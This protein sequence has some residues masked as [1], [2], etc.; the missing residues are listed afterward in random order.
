MKNKGDTSEISYSASQRQPPKTKPNP[1]QESAEGIWAKH[2]FLDDHKNKV[3]GKITKMDAPSIENAPV[4]LQRNRI[5]DDFGND[6]TSMKLSNFIVAGK[7]TY[8]GAVSENMGED[9]AH[10][11]ESE[12][13][14]KTTSQSSR[15]ETAQRKRPSSA[16]INSR[17]ETTALPSSKRDKIEKLPIAPSSEPSEK[18]R[19]IHMEPP[20]FSNNVIAHKTCTVIE[21]K[22]PVA[23]SLENQLENMSSISSCKLENQSMQ[24]KVV[25]PHVPPKGPKKAEVIFIDSGKH[26]RA[27]SA[28]KASPSIQ[29][30]KRVEKIKANFSEVNDEMGQISKNRRNSRSSIQS[31]GNSKRDGS[32][33]PNKQRPSSSGKNSNLSPV[34]QPSKPN[35][36]QVQSKIKDLI[37]KDKKTYTSS[38]P[39]FSKKNEPEVLD[40]EYLTEEGANDNDCT[41]RSRQDN[42]KTIEVKPVKGHSNRGS[43]ELSGGHTLEISRDES[44]ASV[45]SS[46]LLNKE[47]APAQSKWR[48][49]NK[50]RSQTDDDA[51]DGVMRIASNL[52]SSNILKRFN[53][54]S[55]EKNHY[56]KNDSLIDHDSGQEEDDQMTG[57]NSNK[58]DQKYFNDEESKESVRLKQKFFQLERNSFDSDDNKKEDFNKEDY[59]LNFN[60]TSR[61]SSSQFSAFC[62]NEDMKTFFKKE[63]DYREKPIE[64]IQPEQNI[65]GEASYSSSNLTYG[66]NSLFLEK[67][68]SGRSRRENIS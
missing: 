67:K 25:L 9:N 39:V 18:K 10:P 54:Q 1:N 68:L 27:H 11:L 30:K 56:K 17:S 6:V 49:E 2:E 60:E 44:R 46:T 13:R 31:G 65:I 66:Q 3:T 34:S 48:Q 16:N 32:F 52:L 5:P 22:L 15:R 55:S 51:D 19:E 8:H 53:H 63:F 36:K 41:F 47:K 4:I 62:P 7:P 45:S 50:Y 58:Q 59:E 38:G 64:R 24:P 23:Y 26:Q 28:S 21:P 57:Y 42:Q 37:A 40:L 14:K 33:T 12:G 61:V 35:Y 43:K 20:R 29:N